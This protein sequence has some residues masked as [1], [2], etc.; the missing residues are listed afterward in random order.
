MLATGILYGPAG[1][2][3]IS[4][5]NLVSFFAQIEKWYGD[6]PGQIGA[7]DH[8]D[9]RLGRLGELDIPVPALAQYS[10]YDLQLSHPTYLENFNIYV[11]WIPFEKRGAGG[12]TVTL[13]EF[14]SQAA[15]TGTALDFSN[16]FQKASSI[17]DLASI[18]GPQGFGSAQY[19]PAGQALPYTINF[20]NPPTSQTN[21]GEI[22]IVTKLDAGLDPYTFR[23]GDLTIGDVSVHIPSGRALFQGDFD[24]TQSK[25]FILRVSAGIDTKANTA[26]WLL[27]AID[28]KTGEVIQDPSL[29]LLAP[30][31][32]RGAGLGSVSYSIL[33]L[34][35]LPTGTTISAQARVLFNTMAPQDTA[36][37]IQTLDGSAPVTAL[38]A[39]LI[40]GTSDYS[41]KWTATDDSG[42]S[43]VA[44]VTVY[45]SEDGG[46]YAIWLRQS[47]ETSGIY[48]GQVGHTYQFLALATDNAGNTE[49]PPPTVFAP[50]D[51]SQVNLGN[52]LN[53]G[54]S[55]PQD[56]TPPPAPTPST[57]PL[58]IT[59]QQA[60]PAPIPLAKASEFGT[61]IQPF[62]AQSFATGIPLSEA[63]IGP[64]AIVV[65][66]DGGILASGGAN[67]GSLYKFGHDG[68]TAGT[69]LATLDQPIFSMAFDKNGQLW[70]TTG[71][72]P[73]VLL[74]AQTG[75]IKAS[76]G[77]SI[78]QALAVDP[79]TGLI[80]VSSGNG[81]EIFDPVKHT[82]K[83]FSDTRVDDLAFSAEGELWGTSWPTR[84]DILKFNDKGRGQLMVHL[85]SEVDSIAFGQPGTKLDGILFVSNNSGSDANGSELIGIDTATLQQVVIALKGTRGETLETTSDGRLFVA[86]S[87]QIDVVSPIV[88][89]HVAFVN[90]PN[91]AIAPLPLTQIAITFDHD[92]LAGDGTDAASVVNLAN[93]ALTKS[94]GEAVTLT[95]AQYDAATRKVTLG[96]DTIDA[97][98]YSLTIYHSVKS[99]ENVQLDQ[100]F[101]TNFV[102]VSDLSALVSIVF[103]DVRSSR[104]DG[105]VSYD[106]TVTN[107]SD[108][109]IDAPVTLVLDPGQ[110]FQGQ[111]TGASTL[112]SE[113][114]WL[115]DLGVG[116]AGGVLKPGQSTTGQTITVTNPLGQHLSIGNSIF[117]MPTP[118]QAPVFDSSPITAATADQTYQY[119]IAAHDPNG[120]PLTYV[121]L[122]APK[123]MVLDQSSAVL[124]WTPTAL[125]PAQANV[126]LRVYDNRGASASQ[127][128]AIDVVGGNQA[129]IVQDLPAQVSTPEGTTFT[130]SLVATDPDGDALQYFANHL[131]PG[132]LLD[133]ETNQLIWTPGPSS[134]GTYQNVTLGVTDGVNTVTKSFTL[135]V[136]PVNQSPVLTPVPDRTIR[137]GDPVRIQLVAH[138]PEGDALTFSS[139]LLPPG[140]FLDPNTG[141]FEWTP[142]FTQAGIYT[143]PFHVSDGTSDT[144]I[145]TTFTVLNANSAPIFDQLGPYPTLENQ[146]ITFRAFAFDPDNPGF[147]PQDRLSNGQLTQLDG[148]NPTVTYS[149]SGLPDGASFDP[150]TSVFKWTPTFDQAGSYFV[151][152]TAT[153]DG[154]GLA[155]A[156]S[157]LDV[158]INV[159]NVNRPPLVPA[160]TNQ[161][162]D[163]GQV[164]TIPITLADPDQD[165]LAF[166]ALLSRQST[167]GIGAV[168]TT[169]VVLG[170]TS[171]FATVT[172]N[173]DGTYA[174]RFAPGDGDGGNYAIMLQAA[175]NGDGGG[176]AAVLTTQTSFILS[177]PLGNERP[178]LN[179]IGDKVA[180]VGQPLSFTIQAHDPTQDA[181]T[182][183]ADNLP[184]GMTITP[185]PTYGAARIDWTPSAADMGGH[186]ITLHVTDPTNGGTDAQLVN[187]VVRTSNQ[188]PVLLPVGDQTLTEGQLFTLQLKAIDPDGDPITFAAANLP[189]G[190]SLDAKTGLFKW[191]PN[192][193]AAGDYA[194]IV[195]TA[196]D[197]NKSSA[198]TVTLH[199]QNVDRSP[200]LDP[201]ALQAGRE[202]AEMTFTV[203][204]GDPDQDPVLFSLLSP[205]PAGALFNRTTGV[206][207]W[208]PNYDQA[209][210]Y[211]LRFGVTDPYGLQAALDVSVSIANTDRAPTLAPSN[212]QVV[213]GQSLSFN[214]NGADPDKTD[215]L[216]YTAKGLPDGATLDSQT[217]QIQWTPGPGQ[218]GDYLVLA[219]VSDG[220]LSAL[221][222]TV[223]RATTSPQL[224][225]IVIV[226]TPSFPLVPGQDV[227]LHVAATGFAEITSL[228]VTVDGKPVVLDAQ[229]RAHITAGQPGKI[230][231]VAQATDADGLV[232]TSTAQL[233]V[234][235]PND[236][237]APVVGFG[238]N[239][240]GTRVTQATDILGKVSDT[241]LDSWTLEIAQYGSSSFTTIAQ[242]ANAFDSGALI[243]L[244]PA[245]YSNG[246]YTLR[247]T[248]ADVA[249]RTAQTQT[250]IEID[251]QAKTGSYSRT[252][253]DLTAML[254]GHQVAIARQ[255]DSLQSGNAGSFGYGW[256]LALSDTNVQSDVVLTG[257]EDLGDFSPFAEGT[258]VYVTLP[259]GERVGFTF[260]PVKHQIPGLIYY[261]PAFV[262]DPG[263]T[264]TLDSAATQ[265]TRVGNRF[266]DLQTGAPYNPAG[267][268]TSAQYTL[269]SP[270]GT[271][272]EIDASL[273]VSAIVFTDGVRLI[274]A[275]S[276]IYA[277]NGDAISFVGGSNG[278]TKVIGPDGDQVV[279]LYDAQGNLTLARDLV[280]GASSRY[281]YNEAHRL[282][283]VAGQIGQPG[284]S[285]DPQTGVAAPVTADLGSATGYV[286]NS[287]SGTLAAGATDQ[288]SFSVR[289]SEI[290]GTASG[291]IY[292]GVVVTADGGGL[293]P[294]IPVLQGATLVASQAGGNS[295]FGL[296]KVDRSGLELLRITG[297]NGQTA[298]AYKLQLFVAGDVNHDGK[299]DGIDAALAFAAKGSTAGEASYLLGADAN[300]DGKINSTDTQLL[301]QDL[302]YQANQA[303]IARNGSTATHEDLATQV[304][305]QQYISDPEGAPTFYRI[306]GSTNGIAKLSSD[307]QGVVFTP[308]PGFIGQAS[309]EIV[310]DDGYAVSA[311]ATI[312]VNVSNAALIR[313]N[314]P[315]VGPLTTGDTQ[316]LQITG[317]F[318]DATGVA[319]PLSYLNLTSTNPTTVSVNSNGTLRALSSGNSIIIV[320]S[321]GI[322]A[323]KA[324]IVSPPDPTGEG[325]P[326]TPTPLIAYPGALTLLSNGG[327]RQL[328]V[329]TEDGIDVTTSDNGT[330]YFTSNPNIITVSSD[331]FVTG[332][333]SGVATISVIYNGSQS[334]IPIRVENP[335]FGPTL[336]GDQGGVV[337]G[338]DG[339]QVAVG[340]GVLPSPTTV[341]IEPLTQSALPMGVPTGLSFLDGFTLNVGDSLLSQPVQLAVPVPSG[342]PV[343]TTVYFFRLAQLPDATGTEQPL[344]LLTE[345]G[346]VRADGLAHTNSPPYP[347]VTKTGSYLVVVGQSD[348]LL[349]LTPDA[350]FPAI[351]ASVQN[352]VANYGV[353]LGPFPMQMPILAGPEI[354]VINTYS[355]G[356]I[357]TTTTPIFVGPGVNKSQIH[358]DTPAPTGDKVTPVIKS[359]TVTFL[360]GTD[361][362][363]VIDGSQ[364]G[365][366]QNDIVV[367][368]QMGS[369]QPVDRTPTL[370]GTQLT[371]TVPQ[372]IVLGLADITVVRKVGVFNI[373]GNLIGEVEFESKSVT[374]NPQPNLTFN[375]VRP[376]QNGAPTLLDV[377]SSDRQTILQEIPLVSGPL[378][379]SEN[380]IALTVDQTRAYVALATGGIA[381]IDT[382][383]M[384]VTEILIRVDQ[385]Q[386]DG[387]LISSVPLPFFSSLIT[388][389]DFLYAGGVVPSIYAININP[390]SPD[391]HRAFAIPIPLDIAP[392]GVLDMA[393]NADGT[394]LYATVPETELYGGYFS[395]ERKNG[396]IVVVNIDPADEPSN[397]SVSNPDKWNQIIK[398]LDTGLQPD[399]IVA[400]GDPNRMAFTNFLDVDRGFATIQVNNATPLAFDATVKNAAA[401]LT[402][403]TSTQFFDLNIRNARDVVVLPDQ[404]YAFVSDWRLPN[405]N[406]TL[407]AIDQTRGV[408]AK[409]GI[410]KDP[411]GLRLSLTPPTLVG[412]TMPIDQ[413]YANQLSLSADGKYLFA[414]FKGIQQVKVFDVTA[415][416]NIVNSQPANV[417]AHLPLEQIVTPLISPDVPSAIASSAGFVVAPAL[418]TVIDTSIHNLGDV[419]LVNFATLAR[420]ALEV[421]DSIISVSPESFLGDETILA[422]Y[423][424]ANT[425]QRFYFPGTDGSQRY[426]FSYY[427]MPDI[428]RADLD[429]IRSNQ[430]LGE[431]SGTVLY[432]VVYKSQD[433][434]I[435]TKHLLLKM[436]FAD[437]MTAFSIDPKLS[438]ADGMTRAQALNWY[439][440]AQRLKYLGYP[441]WGGTN[442]KV[443]TDTPTH[444]ALSQGGFDFPISAPNEFFATFIS[445]QTGTLRQ[446]NDIHIGQNVAQADPLVVEALKLFE[447]A[448]YP[449]SSSVYVP[450]PYKTVGT[451]TNAP[452]AISPG[453]PLSSSYPKD[454][455]AWIGST[456]APHWFDFQ[457]ALGNTS[458]NKFS[459]AMNDQEWYGTSWTFAALATIAKNIPNLPV[460]GL[461]V[462]GVSN[463]YGGVLAEHQEH[464]N[465][466]DVDIR[467]FDKN[468]QNELIADNALGNSNSVL[469]LAPIS[470]VTSA[471][472]ITYWRGQ[473]R[474]EET[475]VLD[476]IV[477]IVN[478]LPGGTVGPAAPDMPS[479]IGI[480]LRYQR[481]I[482]ALKD[483]YN[484]QLV[485]FYDGPQD[486]SI[487]GGFSNIHLVIKPPPNVP[488]IPQDAATDESTTQTGLTQPASVVPSTSSEAVWQ[489]AFSDW[490]SR[491]PGAAAEFGS[492]RPNLQFT[493]LL[494]ITL[495]ETE[496]FGQIVTLDQNAAGYGWFV[497]ATPVSNEEFLPTSDPNVFVAPPGSPAYGRMDLLTVELHELG[498]V[499]GLGEADSST[500]PNDLMAQ[501]L[502]TGVRRLPSALDLQMLTAALFSGSTPRSA[503]LNQDAPLSLDLAPTNSNIING[504]FAVSDPSATNFG[505][506]LLGGATVQSGAL[507]L[508]ESSN[509]ATR[510]YEDFIVSTDAHSLSF[511]LTGL[512]FGPSGDGP[513]DAFEM[514]LLG[515]DAQSPIGAIGLSNTDAA[516][517][518]QSDGSVFMSSKVRIINGTANLV[519]G[520]PVTISVDL[521]GI[522]AG[523]PLRLYFD[524]IGAGPTSSEVR[525]ENVQLNG[526]TSNTS[527]VAANVTGA[528]LE[529]GPATVVT[530]SYTDP[531]LGDTHS[532]GIDTTGTKGKVTNNGDGTFSYD[533]NGMFKS[534]KAGASTTDT[535]S[536]TVTDGSNVGSTATVTITITG[537]NDA[538]VA[539]NVN[540]SVLEHGPTTVVTASYTDPDLGDT[541][542]FGID[543]TGT[544]GKVTNDGDGT[545]TY[546]PNGMFESLKAGAS[547]ID[548][549]SYTVT[550]GSNVG[551]TATVT[552]TITGQNDAPVAANVN[553]SV[554]EHGPTTVVTASY[555]DPDLGDTHSFGIDT[556]GTKGKVTNNGDGTFTYDPNGAFESLKAGASTTD[557]FSYT[558][559]DGSNAGSTA[560]VTITITGQNDA[561]VAANVIGAVL[562]HGPATTVTASY[563]DPDLGDTHSF[564][565]DTTGTKGKV[566]NN[567]DGT[568]SYDPNGMFESL[569][570]GASTTDTF[571]YTVTDGS[572]AG[573]T[574]TVTITITGQNDAPVAAN[575][576]G[577]VLEHGP[578]TVVTAS[579]TDPD[580]GDTHS[581]GIDTT[582]TKGKVTNNGDGTFTYD[583]NGAFESLTAGQTTTDSFLYTVTDGSSAGSTA[584]VTIT[585]TGQDGAEN[586]APAA[587]NVNGS[588]LEHGPATVVTASYTDPDLGDTH[589]FGIDTTGTK[590]KV[591][592]NGDGTFSYDPNGMFKSLK[593][594]ASTTDTFS[595]TVTDGS[596]V[597]STATVTITITGQNDAPVAANVNG[598]VL[599]HGPTT[600][601]TASYTDPDLGDTHSFGIDTTGT[602][603]KVTN[604]GDGTFTYDPNGMFE[605]LKAGASTID[606]FS[607]TVTDGSNV[608]STATVTITITGQ[609][610]A[611]VAAN[612]NGSVLEHG[613]TTV[614]TASY[615]D[616]DLGDTHSFGIDTTGTKGKVTNNGDGTFTYD[617]N[618]AFE[619]LKAGASTTDTFSYTVTDGSNAGSTAMVT[620][621]IT[622]QN[623]APVAAN[624]IGAVLEH[625]PATTVTAS[626]TDPDL[627][628]THSFGIDTTGTKGKVTNNGDG[629]F[630]YDPNGMFESL[631]AGASTTDTFSY[632]VTDGSNAGSTATVTI[633]ITGQN[634]A[635]VAANVNGSVLEHGP[636]TV[637]TASYTD[638]D[639]GDTHSFGIDTTG[640]KGKVTNNGD[641]TFTY[642]PN[643]AF[644]S[645][646]AGASTSDTFS[647]TVTDGSNAG[648]TA[649]VTIT[650][651]GQNDA[652]VAVN[653]SGAVLEHGPATTVTASYTD[654]DVGDTHSFGIDTTGTK[655]KVTDNGNGTFTY[656]PNGA[657][658][659]L[660]AGTSGIDTFKYTV[661]DAAGAS[662]TATATITIVGQ[663][664][665]PIAR[666]DAYS[667][668]SATLLSVPAASGVLNNDADPDGN[669]LTAVL[670]STTSHGT[671]ALKPDGSFTYTSAAGFVGTDTFTYQAG[672]GSVNSNTAT[673]QL[674][675]S[676]PPNSGPPSQI[677][678]GTP[679]NDNLYAYPTGST[680]FTAEAGDDILHGGP[681]NDWL[682]A[683]PGNDQI[684][685]GA[686]AD[687]FLIYGSDVGKS[688]TDRI[689]DLNFAEGDKIVLA[690]FDSGTFGVPTASTKTALPYGLDVNGLGTAYVAIGSIGDLVI[691]GS[692]SSHVQVSKSGSN[693]LAISITQ[694]NHVE[695]LQLANMY[696]AY[697]AAGGHI[698]GATTTSQSSV[699][700]SAAVT[701]N[702]ATQ[703]ASRLPGVPNGQAAF[704]SP[705]PSASATQVSQPSTSSYNT[706]PTSTTSLNATFSSSGGVKSIA[707]A[708]NY[709]PEIVTVIGAEPGVDLPASAQLTFST[710]QDGQTAEARIVITSDE[711]L[712]GGSIDL[713]SLKFKNPIDDGSPAG[714]LGLVVKDVN[715]ATG[716]APGKQSELKLEIPRSGT[717]VAQE[718]IEQGA[719]E[720]WRI[721]FSADALEQ[722]PNARIR[723]PIA[724]KNIVDA[725]IT[726]DEDVLAGL[727]EI[728]DSGDAVPI[729]NVRIT[730][731]ETERAKPALT[732]LASTKDQRWALSFGPGEREANEP[733]TKLRI[734]LSIHAK[735]GISAHP[736]R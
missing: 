203:L 191:T 333:A 665:A 251:S 342:T 16:F 320:S 449:V 410:I 253:T 235:H 74:D 178:I 267:R 590:G 412:V 657:F 256:R 478:A 376:S 210:Q 73:L 505:W 399:H 28:P 141:A 328:D 648:S 193:L 374:V 432:T 223:I 222:P 115:I 153:D 383:A 299:V 692:S 528:V 157:T 101:T 609:N 6:Q 113:G 669:A 121:L 675:I 54:Q 130:I 211:T 216:A 726:A 400:T 148:T 504:D 79:G 725:E 30:N 280:S 604:D 71:G 517:S 249:G 303:P 392:H 457:T 527:P 190:S 736:N 47:T 426:G 697:I 274:V 353:M 671:L 170:A 278:I 553:G 714:L 260:E 664:D 108:N 126:I 167:N 330:R 695:T 104:A 13:P 33:P 587:A 184:A 608:G 317:D 337:Q 536:Y 394:K 603:G 511:T 482:K 20:A 711:S 105:T 404:S 578:A 444:L 512:N 489:S 731:P 325:D 329:A 487:T 291:S 621:T 18:T 549:F 319:V 496:L 393:V 442:E 653:V 139:P 473:L 111:P 204:A 66:P 684:W 264:W 281:G 300:R 364:F 103:N 605:S 619:S 381:V 680:Y 670:V 89:P 227:L 710:V 308:T 572:N 266:Y 109:D 202:G 12:G 560:M 290:A 571:S 598:S 242:G 551:S 201:M 446:T 276:G 64:L 371:V 637:V 638:P 165:P 48:Q 420:Q 288:L 732:S 479:I 573:S 576:N 357:S 268:D 151:H 475:A 360:N 366:E 631:K 177:V 161:A 535:F 520:A 169:P 716:V 84:G 384:R 269:T 466:M 231:I 340:P 351:L 584:T 450:T 137:E 186:A 406:T 472:R 389:G 494:G 561:P 459:L 677:V 593:A 581:F 271:S 642:D 403:G 373:G 674:Q 661:I 3:V 188:A 707:F 408:G 143:I 41:V 196:S 38:S 224:P 484:G 285:I 415:M 230:T 215:T 107:I 233:K 295:A 283:L 526:A 94:T 306:I 315:D 524:L 588:V 46:D 613:P 72:G 359:A 456:S 681:G 706:Q 469:P 486:P 292:L 405:F 318:T 431:Q 723:L 529:H 713:V 495:G 331:G 698:A 25:G 521:S 627:G 362:Q 596:N 67:R 322:S 443:Q 245:L 592:N 356:S 361:P 114:W 630:S 385:K 60:V 626:Y 106:V 156:T 339:S 696:S 537:Q 539:A 78:T 507:V 237:V 40:Q 218:A 117:A 146:G 477:A 682:N 502:P 265:L 735:Q 311:T 129:P 163:L 455:L 97:A 721:D 534:L 349:S 558:V 559:T 387:S 655:G 625:G 63:D 634:D 182:F 402:L 55:T 540:G 488:T 338:A 336:I 181:L 270:D 433:G 602:K 1:N 676:A 470:D 220:Q 10:T 668:T 293:A 133:P 209:G 247:L 192:F 80:Y 110:Y 298:G 82:F 166:T 463:F 219:T 378:A 69:P 102:A 236:L 441:A 162:V 228:S 239:V 485:V 545:F 15:S 83:H 159:A 252:D 689:N 452:F 372:S 542:S 91:G 687:L 85:D 200:V 386:S 556:T 7:I 347:G 52:V 632:T 673:V 579:Y 411:F 352:P 180:L 17:G 461:Q 136:T 327:Q 550:D 703:V 606:T 279:Y 395:G 344:W 554:L 567:G 194:G 355:L 379:S 35:S 565:I 29:G 68:G 221:A 250:Q 284:T 198:E 391:Y 99:L 428:T 287:Y 286:E 448:V 440:V 513:P 586:T 262:A 238:N 503:V 24:F 119:L 116:L 498:H 120:F 722:N 418:A 377:Y 658:L 623:D 367:R 92:M 282:T 354:L 480:G 471:Q 305:V 704:S 636:A 422:G 39:I 476:Q 510:T 142:S 244:D 96:F 460:S 643:G 294:G 435:G 569:K 390:K 574:A 594:G 514:A 214:L 490:S 19:L 607:Y 369:Q 660:P 304:G 246:F 58:F 23:L 51:G 44:H 289:P 205:L 234:R 628:D 434:T 197:G 591:T 22:R 189:T 533:P 57:N 32:A 259:T 445:G 53:V 346:T 464:R 316:R 240:L 563:T 516:F 600:V 701:T 5:G 667:T 493:N 125:S 229:G 401:M 712:P 570:A 582:G 140:A 686:G 437:G 124:S 614:V 398:T 95:V 9:R 149:V 453:A 132:A 34:S 702:A 530:A 310:A 42:G 2:Q 314:L 690:R 138:D 447:A 425:E 173:P 309:F 334:D 483:I 225:S 49:K 134:A 388:S 348:S 59:A 474:P 414:N 154:N 629:T 81:I 345:T 727:I 719:A 75:Q 31:N 672:D 93:Y 160:L 302:G 734:P 601:V 273:G 232:G 296:Y 152:F 88:S 654:P 708:L 650:I 639:L 301:F 557:T 122:D 715:N 368:Y 491:W 365:A 729:N 640:T 439:E 481:L 616:P 618:G 566:T 208:T 90:P 620:I 641:G 454:A 718:L 61:V 258:R 656:D 691:V 36:T 417:L 646:K 171:G 497:D 424:N 397:P 724:T 65:T 212:H 62:S 693:D 562:E 678:K 589:S 552:I 585:V 595:Y 243:R 14:G 617:P 164:L 396:H 172:Q 56:T 45:V 4:A 112:S 86:Q 525:I 168:D 127:A 683:G 358:I 633:T 544:K 700:Q 720:S 427:V 321:H 254:D 37:L 728:T 199:V 123:G 541:H 26:T 135:E 255:Y 275:E 76:F 326:V 419:T 458:G 150:I 213:L 583:P 248:A 467:I 241:N 518:L 538:P 382:V 128:F 409:I 468:V 118:T 27:Q 506:T 263:V 438:V 436:R 499:L 662:S 332:L 375:I 666:N 612:V 543:T 647:Y 174:L 635:P 206:V 183:T 519:A 312:T 323:V 679:K 416:L 380:P 564:G 577:S 645:L 523:A 610:D 343:G 649:T 568:F 688:D 226:Q 597:G 622:G 421:T 144:P 407:D 492:G 100:D 575:V 730:I 87:H 705:S 207:D 131:P 423:L 8:I 462:T 217:G 465:G 546:D 522:T 155:P 324:V 413:G 11:P 500:A 599:E 176:A 50:N 175:D 624:V 307:G 147:V 187:I 615:T 363:L 548:T 547:T 532:F 335:S 43:G 531:D 21:P 663:N 699:S 651:T 185:L 430:A 644:T 313:I 501:F 341:D 158:S 611:P 195:F 709:D 179:S 515:N 652:P 508:D 733:A 261:T 257:R 297:A 98:A 350:T 685:G 370:S 555:T 509:S 145:T 580:L 659:S 272:Y 451:S 429:K 277:P 77:D 694:T 70:A 717:A